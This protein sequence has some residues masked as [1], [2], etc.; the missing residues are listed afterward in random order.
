[1]DSYTSHGG[2]DSF[3]HVKTIPSNLDFLPAGFQVA[4]GAMEADLLQPVTGPF[5][6]PKHCSL[7]A[8]IY[9][10]NESEKSFGIL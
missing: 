4:G 10:F 3:I 6:E 5:T 7:H 1:M 8:L 2:Y 9:C